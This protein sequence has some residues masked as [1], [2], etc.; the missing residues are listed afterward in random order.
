MKGKLKKN[1]KTI[2][3]D[4]ERSNGGEPQSLGG[5]GEGTEGVNRK[6]RDRDKGDGLKGRLRQYE[7]Y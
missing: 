2:N 3:F 5:I 7:H 4:R 6:G 1:A